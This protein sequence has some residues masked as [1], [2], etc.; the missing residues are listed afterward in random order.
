MK[1]AHI[2]IVVKMLVV[3]MLLLAL[4]GDLVE[5]YYD[6][7]RWVGFLVAGWA[8]YNAYQ[9]R[10][11]IWFLI[12]IIVAVVY[13]PFSRVE[14][15]KSTWAVVN[16]A[17]AVL[18]LAETFKER[19]GLVFRSRSNETKN[20]K[21]KDYYKSPFY[22]DLSDEDKK[23][24]KENIDSLFYP[25]KENGLK[26]IYFEDDAFISE[27]YATKFIN[28]GYKVRHFSYP[29]K[30]VLEKIDEFKPDLIFTDIIMPETDGYKLIEA[31]RK[32]AKFDSIPIF[33][34]SNISSEESIEKAKGLGA[35][36]YFVSASHTPDQLIEVIDKELKKRK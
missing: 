8:A 1:D 21:E 15:D 29:P 28:N 34:I 11:T 23:E 7:L 20:D 3:F 10:D 4:E 22:H 30:D 18:I 2:A 32:K 14:F 27:I 19:F 33:V 12:M 36:K 16:S 5:G 13:N 25:K 31:V 24:K 35:D 9:Q 6:L 26:I 17:V